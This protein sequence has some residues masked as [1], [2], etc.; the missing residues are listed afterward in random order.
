[1]TCVNQISFSQTLHPLII[2]SSIVIVASLLLLLLSSSSSCAAVSS[3]LSLLAHTLPKWTDYGVSGKVKSKL[4]KCRL[5]EFVK[6]DEAECPSTGLK[7][8]AAV[9]SIA[10]KKKHSLRS[11]IK[12]QTKVRTLR[13]ADT[14]RCHILLPAAR[15]SLPAS[16]PF[17]LVSPTGTKAGGGR[18]WGRRRGEFDSVSSSSRSLSLRRHSRFVSSSEP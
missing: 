18:D 2:I 17:P 1:M 16:P 8:A 13:A 9:R 12:K 3:W 6:V 5:P 4:K 14:A 10:Q 7:A 11:P 15:L